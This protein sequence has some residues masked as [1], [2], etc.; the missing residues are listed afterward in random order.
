[1]LKFIQTQICLLFVHYFKKKSLIILEIDL[2]FVSDFYNYNS[3]VKSKISVT[4]FLIY[5]LV[6]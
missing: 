1:M 4:R 5:R 6:I 2:G 3:S